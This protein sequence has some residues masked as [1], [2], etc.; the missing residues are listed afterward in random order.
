MV[1]AHTAL[2]VQLEPWLIVAAGLV[3]VAW[4]TRK[5][6]TGDAVDYLQKAN[7][8]LHE[9]NDKL[10]KENAELIVENAA[11]HSKTDF[12]AAFDPLKEQIANHERRADERAKAT[13]TVLDMIAKRLGRESDADYEARN[14]E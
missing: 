10:I 5:G 12:A 2:L 7:G 6:N 11:M 13:L 9:Q 3:G 8:V 14:H 4:L 1:F